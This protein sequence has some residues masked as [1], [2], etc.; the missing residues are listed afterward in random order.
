MIDVDVSLLRNINQMIE[1]GQ[2]VRVVYHQ[3]T[4]ENGLIKNILSN[5]QYD[6]SYANGNSRQEINQKYVRLRENLKIDDTVEILKGN[7]WI[8]GKILNVDTKTNS[9]EI[10]YDIKQSNESNRIKFSSIRR[11]Y[12]PLPCDSVVFARKLDWRPGKIIS[13]RGNGIF[14]V[15]LIDSSVVL[16]VTNDRIRLYSA[17]NEI[18]SSAV[19]GFGISGPG[20][21]ISG[22]GSRISGPGSGSNCTV[23]EY[24]NNAF[25]VGVKVL[26]KIRKWRSA[27]IKYDRRDGT[28]DVELPS[29]TVEARVGETLL[30]VK[31][32]S[33]NENKI[34]NENDNE[35]EKKQLK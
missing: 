2:K 28:Y 25:A 7:D 13:D 32:I 20:S 26:A 34:V 21:K 17:K 9:A 18:T 6:V 22:P 33:G 3:K 23:S 16:S 8:S 31:N 10:Q 19:L 14:D 27:K 30:R 29:G 1:V 4:K 12:P 24:E 15:S 11:S 35:N 5:N